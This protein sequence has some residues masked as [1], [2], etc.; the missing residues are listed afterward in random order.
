M[1]RVNL[2]PPHL[3]P[4]KRTPLPHI[5][6]VI[7]LILAIGGMAY[8]FLDVRGQITATRLDLA[9]KQRAYQQLE[10][11]V[12]EFNQ[13]NEKKASLRD[14]IGVIQDILA[15]R[16]VWSE[17]LNRLI[18]ITP[19]NIWYSGMTVTTQGFPERRQKIDPKTNQVM[20]DRNTG[21][22]VYESV[23]VRRRVLAVSGYAVSDERGES[24]IYPLAEISS[25]DPQFSR[26]FKI[27]RPR[28]QDTEFQGFAVRGFTLEYL[29]ETPGDA[30]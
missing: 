26:Y 6:S 28:M 29:I 27:T 25:S 15:D 3:R 10:D 18:E 21:Q 23:T 16:I 17:Q 22:P 19:A 24:N 13:L 12:R 14:K 2:M 1:I 7:V 11:T 30:Q 4:I 9:D 8:L 5:A 20:T